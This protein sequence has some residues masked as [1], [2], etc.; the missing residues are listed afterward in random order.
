MRQYLFPSIRRFRLCSAALSLACVI[1]CGAVAVS[2][3]AQEQ[4]KKPPVE[5]EE[6]V[7]SA[8]PKKQVHVD[9]EEP[10]RKTGQNE[11]PRLGELTLEAEQATNPVL[12]DLFRDLATPYDMVTWNDQRRNKVAPVSD[13]VGPKPN[14]S[15]LGS[16]RVNLQM[17]DE[18]GQA[19][20]MMQFSLRDLDHIDHYEDIA[21][22]RVQQF[23]EGP[24]SDPGKGLAPSEK[25]AAAEKVLA[26]VFRFHESARGNGPRDGP[27]WAALRDRLRKKLREVQFERLQMMVDPGEWT[28]A[29]EY[30][31]RL[32]KSYPEPE[33]QNQLATYLGRMVQQSMQKQDYREARLRLAA[34]EDRFHNKPVIDEISKVL[35]NRAEELV[36][37]ARKSDDR[38]RALELIITADSVWPNLPGLRDYMDKLKNVL[39]PTLEVG[40][41]DL[42]VK[43]S[44]AAAVTDSERQAVELLFESLVKPVDVAGV[45]QEYIAGLTRGTP[46]VIPLGRK[47][48]LVRNAFWSDSDPD[49]RD[50]EVGAGDVAFTIKTLHAS[51]PQWTELIDALP[52][53]DAGQ[54]AIKLRQGYLEPLSLMSFKILPQHVNMQK[55]DEQ[56]IGSGPFRLQGREGDA[57]VF[58]ANPVYQ[59]NDKLGQPQIRKVRLFQSPNP[60]EDFS[61]GRLHVLLD[62]PI[63]G[64]QPLLSVKSVEVKKMRNRRVYFLAVNHR[65]PALGGAPGQTVRTAIAHAID[66]TQ[67]LDDV[68]RGFLKGKPDV[69]HR[70]LN[71]PYPPGSWACDPSIRPDPHDRLLAKSLADGINGRLKRNGALH[72][73][74]PADDDKARQ[75]CEAIRAQVKDATGI[76]LQ[77][78]PRSPH[79]L[80]DDV[81]RMHEYELAYYYFDYPDNVFWL[82]PLFNPSGV[83]NGSNYLG[84]AEDSELEVAFQAA[85][86]HRD[87][88]E[89]KKLTHN[90]HRMLYTKMPLIPLW[91]LDTYVAFHKDVVYAPRLDPLRL[92]SDIEE[93][94]LRRPD[95]AP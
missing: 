56:P 17:Y 61:T 34:L 86:A 67:I 37:E 31:S 3:D 48:Q 15:A 29:F 55:F 68:F 53:R 32:A 26:A 71:G 75:A 43:M 72:L 30:A 94:K 6:P 16:M 23:L 92:F 90:I 39:P 88:A 20:V 79:E 24:V 50:K 80:H 45:G 9:E 22:A 40:V 85:M 25:M 83:D 33:I 14:M 84:Y 77:L 7:K 42:P 74:Y 66:R 63:E 81:E 64:I 89:V 11:A 21:L 10:K 93:W 44:P 19:R 8:K 18:K 49:K 1:V 58:A 12:R 27:S 41:R 87:F 82:W 76:D 46:Q 65:V 59:R 47:F 70:P 91:Q 54:I 60:S 52:P 78:V 95:A 57:V 69:P 4:K 13:Y 38:G 28:D 5:E 73:K 36:A 35:K 51:A 2:V 62:L